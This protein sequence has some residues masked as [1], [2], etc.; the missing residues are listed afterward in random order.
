MEDQD[1]RNV[2][3]AVGIII[4][5]IF[6]VSASIYMIKE[7]YGLS[8]SCQLSLPIFISVLTSLGVF[9]GILTY[10]FLSKSFSKKKNELFG[11]VDKTLTFL[12][13]QEREI[14]SALIKKG[15][16]AQNTLGKITKMDPVKLHRRLSSLE[17]RGV[18]Q[19]KKT[20]MTNTIILDKDLKSIF[21][22]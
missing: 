20:G 3:L 15:D 8:C 14:I 10:Y 18:L 13:Q 21:I 22:K 16:I 11:N 2:L 17:S 4:G 5:F 1:L 19:K 7:H 6:V 12:E 9:V